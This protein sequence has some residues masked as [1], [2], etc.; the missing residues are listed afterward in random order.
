[1]NKYVLT[2]KMLI[3]SPSPSRKCGRKVW[4][5]KVYEFEMPDLREAALFIVGFMEVLSPV[6]FISLQEVK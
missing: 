6:Q 4:K 3:W 1:M 2:Y 5:V